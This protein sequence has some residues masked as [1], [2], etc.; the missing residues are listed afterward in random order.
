M[1][2]ARSARLAEPAAQRAGADF[3]MTG[4]HQAPAAAGRADTLTPSTS[5]ETG[6]R[7]APEKK[8]MPVSP[9]GRSTSPLRVLEASSQETRFN[10]WPQL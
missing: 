3:T 6:C 2:R 5:Q 8:I 1:D 10:S 4:I 9:A 7:P